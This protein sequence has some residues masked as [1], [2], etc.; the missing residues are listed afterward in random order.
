MR[1]FYKELLQLCVVRLGFFEDE[2][3]GVGVF[4]EREEF[5]E[6]KTHEVVF[7]VV[8]HKACFRNETPSLAISKRFSAKL[9]NSTGISPI[10]R[11][12]LRCKLPIVKRIIPGYTR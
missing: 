4:S 9:G 10:V 6:T 1:T 11:S 5:R 12:Y 8:D 2:Y 3:V 7:Q